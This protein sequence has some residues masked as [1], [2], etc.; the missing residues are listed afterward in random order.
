MILLSLFGVGDEELECQIPEGSPWPATVPGSIII[1]TPKVV[2]EFQFGL[3][4]NKSQK[5][6]TNL[7][8]DDM[9]DAEATVDE[10]L[11]DERTTGL[12]C[13]TKLDSLSLYDKDLLVPPTGAVHEQ[14]IREIEDPGE[15]MHTP[16][17]PQ[18]APSPSSLASGDNTQ[19][20]LKGAIVPQPTTPDRQKSTSTSKALMGTSNKLSSPNAMNKLN[21][22]DPAFRRALEALRSVDQQKQVSSDIPRPKSVLS[23]FRQR[24]KSELADPGQNSNKIPASL[25]T[26]QASFMGRIKGMFSK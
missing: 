8:D 12:E 9:K 21:E 26:K 20:P 22:Q 24:S 4:S 15:P 19:A 18:N 16:D 10:D 3:L 25:D 5:T 11:N 13:L 2:S 23:S 1:P 7:T 14:C 6:L 17:T